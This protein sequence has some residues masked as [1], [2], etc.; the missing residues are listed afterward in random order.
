[1]TLHLIHAC[2]RCQYFEI[3][4]WIPLTGES[5]CHNCRGGLVRRA[6]SMVP[7]LNR[8]ATSRAEQLEMRDALWR[9]PRN[10]P[11]NQT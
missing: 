4:W 8:E 11:E 3:R 1:M 6:G 7:L 10:E 5:L 2:D 9:R